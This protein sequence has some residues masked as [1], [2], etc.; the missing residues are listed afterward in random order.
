[1]VV[2]GRAEVDGLLKGDFF[3]TV[4]PVCLYGLISAPAAAVDYQVKGAVAV[5][6]EPGSPQW[7]TTLMPALLGTAGA[8]YALSLP[9][10]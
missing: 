2:A 4:Y 3:L 8:L 9:E 1:M 7:F 5:Q 6:G 10:R